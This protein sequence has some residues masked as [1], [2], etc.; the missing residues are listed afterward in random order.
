[1]SRI[2][3]DLF[4]VASF[5]ISLKCYCQMSRDLAFYLFA[6]F[7]DEHLVTTFIYVY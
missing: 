4:I 3:K 6:Y 7:I 2:G 5:K 1:M